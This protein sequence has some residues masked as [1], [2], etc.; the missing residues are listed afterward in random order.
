MGGGQ[1]LE[2]PD[3]S[4]PTQSFD[5]IEFAGVHPPAGG[6]G[7]GLGPLATWAFASSGPVIGNGVGAAGLRATLGGQVAFLKEKGGDQAGS[8]RELGPGLWVPDAFSPCSPAL[9]VCH[10]TLEPPG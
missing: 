6:S 2:G 3:S 10:P 9:E 5:K 4:C 7:P 1:G 8:G